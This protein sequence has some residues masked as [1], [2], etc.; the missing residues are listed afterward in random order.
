MKEDVVINVLYVDDEENNLIAFKAAF[1]R[2]FTI[3]TALSADIAQNILSQNNIHVLITDQRMPGTL[4]TELLAQAA[5]DY[6]DQTRLL[7]TGYSDIE[8]L[9]DAVNRGHIFRYLQ[10]PWNDE[11]LKKTIEDSFQIYFIKK[12]QK[13][14]NEKLVLTN[15]QLEF[16]LRQKLIS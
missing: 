5:I 4:G 16:M 1:R 11:E 10:K 6:P 13:E 15:E 14:Q 3:Y 9:K 8:A 2:Y 12:E 7:L